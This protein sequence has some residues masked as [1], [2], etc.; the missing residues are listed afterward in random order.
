MEH[1]KPLYF[2]GSAHPE[3]AS[4]DAVFSQSFVLTDEAKLNIGKN[5]YAVNQGE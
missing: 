5:P 4:D 1:P 2:D 3:A